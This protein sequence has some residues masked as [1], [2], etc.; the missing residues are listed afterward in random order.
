[1]AETIDYI[2][3]ITEFVREEETTYDVDGKYQLT[4][5]YPVTATGA[6]LGAKKKPLL[7]AFNAGGGTP[8]SNQPRNHAMYAAKLGYVGGVPYYKDPG[9]F[10]QQDQI[11]GACHAWLAVRSARANRDRLGIK[12]R[13]IFLMGNS[14]GAINSIHA[15]MAAR[16]MKDKL[17]RTFANPLNDQYPNYSNSVRATCSISGAA[18]DFFLKYLKKGNA[19]NLF[20]H[21]ELDQT[22]TTSQAV[23]TFEAMK[24]LGVYDELAALGFPVESNMVIYKG[25]GHAVGHLDEINAHIFARFAALISKRGD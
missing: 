17:D 14:A 20:H 11:L 21:G 16:S 9:Q 5:F 19:P 23:K 1:M 22:V 4:L 8:D 3:P 15:E 12:G 6:P 24:A 7:L 2:T 18:T 25:E 13:D 10:E